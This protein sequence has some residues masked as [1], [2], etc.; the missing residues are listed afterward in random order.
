MFKI[1]CPEFLKSL[2]A[3][4]LQVSVSDS[5][6]SSNLH[7][8]TL[9]F[10]NDFKLFKMLIGA[11]TEFWIKMCT[12]DWTVTECDQI[13]YAGFKMIFFFLSLQIQRV[14][15]KKKPSPYSGGGR[16]W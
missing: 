5:G 16:L 15:C 10:L 12:C 1:Q 4:N 6:L 7:K 13:K 8:T 14:E 3:G 2:F 11:M 9:Y